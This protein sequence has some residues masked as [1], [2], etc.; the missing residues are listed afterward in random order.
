MPGSVSIRAMVGRH[1]NS[2]KMNLRKNSAE[3]LNYESVFSGQ[4]HTLLQLKWKKEVLNVV[5]NPLLRHRSVVHLQKNTT[6]R[7]SRF[8]EILREKLS[9]LSYKV[10]KLP[11][12]LESF[13]PR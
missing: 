3:P 9:G 12:L 8:L 2:M 10:Q 1:H 5:D 4:G 13:E 7:H 11:T 6:F